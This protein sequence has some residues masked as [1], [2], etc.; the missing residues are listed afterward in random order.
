ME[1]R[2]VPLDKNPKQ[3][4]PWSEWPQSYTQSSQRGWELLEGSP[5]SMGIRVP[6][7]GVLCVS[8]TINLLFSVG[9]QMPRTISGCQP[10]PVWAGAWSLLSNN[11]TE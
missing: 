3:M 4:E 8:P 10:V 1:K 9:S 6:F 7:G 11:F 5:I 2:F